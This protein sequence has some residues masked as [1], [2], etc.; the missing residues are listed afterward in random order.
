MSSFHSFN[1]LYFQLE[2]LCENEASSFDLLLFPQKSKSISAQSIE[3]SLNR[4]SLGTSFKIRFIKFENVGFLEDLFHSLYIYSSCNFILAIINNFF[5]F[6]NY[7]SCWYTS[8]ITSSKRNYTECTTMV[9]S[10][11]DFNIGP[12]FSIKFFYERWNC[13]IFF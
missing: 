6:V 1:I 7:L 4:C 8:V 13:F 12:R 9:T 11:L 3:E 10:L 5:Y 2:D